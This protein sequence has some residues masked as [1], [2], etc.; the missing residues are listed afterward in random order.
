MAQGGLPAERE[1]GRGPSFAADTHYQ[2]FT[3]PH[4]RPHCLH[5]SP[6]R[7]SWGVGEGGELWPP[8]PTHSPCLAPFSI[9]AKTREGH[10]PFWRRTGAGVAGGPVEVRGRGL[11]LAAPQGCPRC[12][13]PALGHG[14]PDPHW[15]PAPW[16]ALQREEAV[17]AVCLKGKPLQLPA[18]M[19]EGVPP[20]R[21]A[22]QHPCSPRTVPFV[23]S[24]GPQYLCGG[25]EHHSADPVPPL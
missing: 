2:S 11:A 21:E 4:S 24:R 9:A 12:G 3:R 15:C 7:Q 10:T 22:L 18:G 16:S 25:D 8:T 23:M 14:S 6:C 19:W 13:S 1:Q 17:E 20:H 5:T